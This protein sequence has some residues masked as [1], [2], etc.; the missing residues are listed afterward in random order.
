[1]QYLYI[2]TS[3]PIDHRINKIIVRVKCIVERV[4]QSTIIILM[5]HVEQLHLI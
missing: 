3:E 2:A 1:M 4:E 5:F